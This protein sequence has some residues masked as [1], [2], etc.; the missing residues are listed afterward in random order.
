M[1]TQS[2]WERN[3]PNSLN[4]K[5]PLP[6]SQSWKMQ[7]T[8]S[9][10]N[11]WKA[12]GYM[13]VNGYV[14]WSHPSSSSVC[15]SLFRLH[16]WSTSLKQLPLYCLLTPDSV[17]HHHVLTEDSFDHR[18]VIPDTMGLNQEIFVNL[19][20]NFLIHHLFNKNWIH[21]RCVKLRY[22]WQNESRRRSLYEESHLMETDMTTGVNRK[23]WK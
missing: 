7:K 3:P 15:P 11:R 22:D 9:M 23:L 16:Q 8:V 13:S 12:S 17:S 14:T 10:S 2:K 21:K 5:E 18:W 4:L 1:R 19:W 6:Q 20:V